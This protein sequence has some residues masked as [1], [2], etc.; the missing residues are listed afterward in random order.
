MALYAHD[1]EARD[2]FYWNGF[3]LRCVDAVRPLE[4]VARDEYPGYTFCELPKEETSCIVPLKNGLIGHL[5]N[6]PMFMP[7]FFKV[8]AEEVSE[9]SKKGNFRYFVA[10]KGDR[11][12]AYIMITNEGENFTCDDPGTANICGAYMF[13]EY[14]GSGVYT[15]LL[16]FL[17]DTLAREGYSRCGVDFESF[18]PTA[19]GFW[20]KHFTTY[21]HSVVRRID[22]RIVKA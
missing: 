7:F 15:G 1:A 19:G 20:L 5:Q 8:T 17:I 9:E 4:P 2:S 10:N 22:E 18:N 14:R 13:P 21:T 16:A 11:T 12:V 6:T 3:G